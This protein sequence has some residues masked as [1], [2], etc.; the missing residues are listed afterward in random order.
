MTVRILPVCTGNICRS[1]LA[2]QLL[3]RQLDP[4]EFTL[5][6]AGVAAVV[7]A[8]MDPESQQV[9]ERLGVADTREHVAQQ[10]TKE[11]LAE[12]DLVLALTLE[13]R[14]QIVELAPAA[15]RYKYT[16]RELARIVDKL[17]DEALPGVGSDTD[18]RERMRAALAVVASRRGTLPPTDPAN[19]DVIDPYRRPPRVHER[20][21]AEVVPAVNSIADFLRRS[22][23]RF[24]PES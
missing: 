18:P 19:L 20:A 22:V 24:P 14:R 12:S 15:T 3:R 17:P 11:L 6:S 9:A 23:S 8:P 16:L 5:S 4:R 7:G 21:A 2:M 10:L 1:P 13:H